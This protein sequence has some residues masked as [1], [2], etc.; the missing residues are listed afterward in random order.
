MKKDIKLCRYP[1]RTDDSFQA[2][3]S[4]DEYIISFLADNEDSL[5]NIL[6]I[7]DEFG[8]LALNLNYDK[9]FLVNDYILSEKGIVE[10]FFR[11]GINQDKISHLSPY[12]KFPEKIDYIIIKIPKSNDYLKFLIDKINSSYPEGTKVI[13]SAMVKYLNSSIYSLLSDKLSN[14]KYSYSWKK[15]KVITAVVKACDDEVQDYIHLDI[16]E[17]NIKMVNKINSFSSKKLDLGTRF[18]LENVDKMNIDMWDSLIDVCC[19]NGILGIYLAKTKNISRLIFSDISYSAIES[20]KDNLKVNQLQNKESQVY[21]DNS[22]DAIKEVG[23]DAIVCNPP[24]HDKHK[25]SISTALE[26]FEASKKVLKVNGKL[27]IVANR[28][29]GYQQ[30]LTKIFTEVKILAQNKKF[31]II[32]SIKK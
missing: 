9:A 4:A 3:N 22:L 28:H 7:E 8:A 25:I 10:N 26:I 17:F 21:R 14:L 19:G 31:V 30:H 18:F 6:I 15:S 20:T 16:P 32:E 24:F 12:E 2:W 23:V 11:N 27:F 1:Y 13:C 5:G 29:L